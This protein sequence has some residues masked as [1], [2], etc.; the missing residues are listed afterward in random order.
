MSAIVRVTD[1]VEES[2]SG[3]TACSCRSPQPSRTRPLIHSLAAI[4]GRRQ[5]RR[6]LIIRLERAGRDECDAMCQ[7]G[8]SV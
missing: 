5:I 8:R 2:V 1:N 7:R 4:D 6:A 3:G